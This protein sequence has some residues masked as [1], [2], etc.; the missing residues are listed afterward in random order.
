[1]K[2]Y[3]VIIIGGGIIGCAV[4]RCL[5]Q[6]DLRI[7][8]CEAA[9]DIATGATKGNGGIV[10]SGYDPQPG[11]LK[12]K[13]NVR[14]N[15][16]YS[17]WSRQLGFAFRRTGSMVLG[18]NNSDRQHLEELLA[19]GKKNGVQGLEL[20]EGDRIRQLEPQASEQAC[21]ALYCPHTGIVDPFEVTI[22]CAENAAENGTDFYLNAPVTAIR[23]NGEEFQV[24]TP[25]GTFLAHWLVNAAGC[26]A[27][28]V[29]RLA[30]DDSFT[31]ATR[32]GDLLI[33]DKNCGVHNLM[34]LYPVPT[35]ET[36]GVVALSTLSGNVLVG[37]SAVMRPKDD[38][39]SYK[40][41]ID[42][43]LTGVHKLVPS[44]DLRR[45]IRP[46]AGQRAVWLEGNND[47]LIRP[48]AQAPGLIHVA[49]IQSPGV[50][51][52]PA[53]AEYTVSLL[54]ENGLPLIHR[55]NYIAIRHPITDFSEATAKEK[56]A[57][58][59]QDPRFGQIVCRCETVTEAEIVQAIHRSPGAT[60]VDGVKRRTRAGMGRCQGGFC[61]SRV[62]AILCRELGLPPEQILLENIG[63]NLLYGN[64]KEGNPHV[65]V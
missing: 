4:A 53:I 51:S 14:G 35:P 19:R 41:G 37:S 29:A 1:M 21:V 43:L 50:A 40:E 49:G 13:L 30:G 48:S 15:Q 47:F 55:K 8:L 61:Q 38:N 27:D 2:K 9:T 36:K 44:I 16:L 56:A 6:Y 32:H 5:C 18:F 20:I 57:L 63:S 46:F 42:Q 3:D 25:K 22:A 10:H 26:H 60:T 65:D 58:I 23:R 11:T 39:D 52:A 7:A 62:V 45:V 34:V 17:E 28:D 54:S 33:F 31:L 59:A 64:V 12:A 24:F